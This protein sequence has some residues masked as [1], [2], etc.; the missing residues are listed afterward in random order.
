[1]EDKSLLLLQRFVRGRQESAFI[2]ARYVV[3]SIAW[4]E[5]TCQLLQRSQGISRYITDL[6]LQDMLPIQ[7]F[8]GGLT[9]W[10]LVMHTVKSLI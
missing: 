8:Q 4:P 1:M 10:S 3:T 5:M 9:D 2:T 6:D 7:T